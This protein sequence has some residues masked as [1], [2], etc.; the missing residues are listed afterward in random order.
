VRNALSKI[1][2]SLIILFS[3]SFLSHAQDNRSGYDIDLNK[4]V[5]LHFSMKEFVAET[6]SF[7]FPRAD[8][9][10]LHKNIPVKENKISL[11]RVG[12][13]SGA[14]ISILGGL[15]YRWKTAWWNNGSAK[16]HFLYNDSYAKDLDKIGHMTGGLFIAETFGVGLKWAGLDDES[17]MLYGALLS[18]LVYTGVE[19]KDGFAPEW[20]FDPVDLGASVAG[21]FFP[22]AQKKIPFLN[23]FTVKYSY[24][25]S[26]SPFYKYLGSTS[27]NNQFFNDDYEGET[28]W[29]SADIKNLSP[30]T[31][32][33]FLPDFLNLAC[34]VSVEDLID[35]PNKHLVFVISPDFD[36]IKL[37]KPDTEFLKSVCQ[38]LNHIHI[39]MPGLKVSPNFKG[40]WLY[41]KP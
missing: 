33:S 14:T 18:T 9:I 23:N 27:Q 29:L 41:L 25:P 19:L 13:V 37:F 24:W 7:D 34:G 31:L 26:N 3:L 17:S 22:Y 10:D 16:F 11:A 2:L 28:F 32:N 20:G 39:P 38:L 12:I 30:K 36:L 4:N 15:Y 35:T 5:P 21:A 8:S 40:Y 6:D 1:L